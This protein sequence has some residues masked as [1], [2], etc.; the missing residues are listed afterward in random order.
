MNPAMPMT[1]PLGIRTL[2]IARSPS[3]ADSLY[4]VYSEQA[5]FRVDVNFR[6]EDGGIWL[7]GFTSP[8]G[9]VRASVISQSFKYSF[10]TEDGTPWGRT[11]EAGFSIAGKFAVEDEAGKPVGFVI[12]GL[13]SVQFQ[14]S[15][16]KLIGK[17]RRKPE[18]PLPILLLPNQAYRLDRYSIEITDRQPFDLR[19][20]YCFICNL[21]GSEKGW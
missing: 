8:V 1:L 5:D 18:K 11:R 13:K 9:I 20:L 14:S 12:H 19:L 7:I 2:T 6:S 16:G 4:V 21:Y 3:G 10:T 15:K 17:A